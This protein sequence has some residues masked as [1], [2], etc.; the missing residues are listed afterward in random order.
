MG[1]FHRVTDDR[2]PPQVFR[3]EESTRLRVGRRFD[4]DIPLQD[5]SVSR[6]HC[7]L[8]VREQCVLVTDTL[9]RNGV[10]LNSARLTATGEAGPGDRIRLAGAWI[11][12]LDSP[13]IT[14]ET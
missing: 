8:E 9:S 6:Q 4:C 2:S 13:G 12:V 3:L 10:W 11:E 1:L 7:I 14:P 5:R